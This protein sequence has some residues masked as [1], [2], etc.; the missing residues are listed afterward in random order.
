MSISAPRSSAFSSPISNPTAFAQR[1][2]VS[3]TPPDALSNLP[4]SPGSAPQG[5]VVT[6]TTLRPQDTFLQNATAETTQELL[7]PVFNAL[8][9]QTGMGSNASDLQVLENF[10]T[11]VIPE[12]IVQLN[13]R[14]TAL[15]QAEPTP[16]NQL[17]LDNARASLGLYEQ[18]GAL[19]STSPLLSAVPQGLSS[20][21]ISEILQTAVI[22]AQDKDSYSSVPYDKYLET[23]RSPDTIFN[24][25]KS[26]IDE[27]IVRLDTLSETASPEDQAKY[28]RI[29]FL[30]QELSGLY[31]SFPEYT[32]IGD[33]F[34]DDVTQLSTRI[35][36]VSEALTAASGDLP[37]ED[38]D[39]ISKQLQDFSTLASELAIMPGRPGNLGYS[40]NFTYKRVG[41]IEAG[42][43]T[44]ETSDIQGAL[45][46]YVNDRQDMD[47]F[48]ARFDG[49]RE[50]IRSGALRGQKAIDEALA[51][52]PGT[53]PKFRAAFTQLIR[54]ELELAEAA[55]LRER[56]RAE[57]DTADQE[58]S[59]GNQNLT[60]GKASNDISQAAGQQS[61]QAADRQQFTEARTQGDRATTAQQ[62]GDGELTRA[63][64]NADTAGVAIQNA[65]AY[66]SR[67]TQLTGSAGVRADQA[68]PTLRG[69]SPGFEPAIESTQAEVSSSQSQN[70]EVSAQIGTSRQALSQLQQGINEERIR[71]E[72]LRQTNLDNETYVDAQ[73]TYYQQQQA[74]QSITS[75]IQRAISAEGG[76]YYHFKEEYEVKVGLGS[77]AAGLALATSGTIKIGVDG[78]IEGDLVSFDVK[79]DVGLEA[80]VDAYILQLKGK[81]TAGGSYGIRFDRQNAL[82]FTRLLDD[83]INVVGNEGVSTGAKQAGDLLLQ[84]IESNSRTESRLTLSGSASV[85]SGDHTSGLAAE[86]KVAE[87]VTNSS[88]DSNQNGRFDASDGTTTKISHEASL[89]VTVEAEGQKFEV[90]ISAAYDR[91]TGRVSAPTL[92]FGYE[93]NIPA[94]A[95]AQANALAIE[96]GFITP[97]QAISVDKFNEAQRQVGTQRPSSIRAKDVGELELDFE[98][99]SVSL[100]AG[101]RY[102]SE[103]DFTVGSTEVTRKSSHETG[104]KVVI[105]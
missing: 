15:E 79:L 60:Q 62:T 78:K 52:I 2:S 104:V 55:R 105:T 23:P 85:G 88:V 24:Q 47:T 38:I 13:E 75:D 12:A 54:A 59:T 66:A 84:F 9:T 81:I 94:G 74:R 71:N 31:G 72:D 20:E 65:T 32:G 101:T 25:R 58:I 33:A 80:E 21:A 14:I 30:L 41:Q 87:I 45:A 34:L 90:T 73:E 36:A 43:R 50:R 27:Q 96:N 76:A 69:F 29:K 1:Q 51:A 70:A 56:A 61:R 11:Q 35:Q 77:K 91:E 5:P 92:K 10:S 97:D 49:L 37:P 40:I 57:L 16:E 86:V 42:K 8:R 63:Q 3:D 17:A 67:A 22:P 18:A 103:D 4:S 102:K 26:A 99:G 39:A 89:K 19:L 53:S 95:I 48:I 28:Q 6:E 7:S 100:S 93:G 64:G 46:S 82:E 98:E 44:R 83:F 68:A